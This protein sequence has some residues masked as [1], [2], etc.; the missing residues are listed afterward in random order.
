LIALP[1]FT[2]IQLAVR[3]S[4]PDD[5]EEEKGAE[6]TQ[7]S[8]GQLPHHQFADRDRNLTTEITRQ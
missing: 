1:Q 3:I 6:G 8:R 5:M 7:K 2:E 4:V